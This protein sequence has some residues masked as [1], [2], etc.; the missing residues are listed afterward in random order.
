MKFPHPGGPGIGLAHG[1]VGFLGGI[2]A[3]VLAG[4][5]FII[6]FAVVVGLLVVLVRFLLVAT[7]AAELYIANNSPNR[8]ATTPATTTQAPAAAKPAPT[9]TTPTKLAP[10]TPSSGSK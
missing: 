1:G 9:A 3:D 5:V 10:R 4:L 7:R 8:S 6:C 2:F